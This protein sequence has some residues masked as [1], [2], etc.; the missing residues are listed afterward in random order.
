MQL[1][2]PSYSD[3][4]ALI[5]LGEK[6]SFLFKCFDFVVPFFRKLLFCVCVVGG[7]LTT[8]TFSFC[9]MARWLPCLCSGGRRGFFFPPLHHCETTSLEA[10]IA[11]ARRERGGGSPWQWNTW[12]T[13]LCVALFNAAHSLNSLNRCLETGSCLFWMSTHTLHLFLPSP[14]HHA[15]Y[16][17]CSPLDFSFCLPP[18][19][20]LT[21]RGPA[22]GLPQGFGVWNAQSMQYS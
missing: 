1:A 12:K 14:P 4:A 22:P 19:H 15:C 21:L 16:G 11:L 3:M 13:Q 6:K 20:C 10:K 7:G 8:T 18:S 5:E 9:P 2:R 17:V